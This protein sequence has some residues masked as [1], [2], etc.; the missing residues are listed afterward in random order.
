MTD[1]AFDEAVQRIE[2][3]TKELEQIWNDFVNAVNVV[4]PRLPG[5]LQP[6]AKRSFNKLSAEH[7][8]V[9]E[10]IVKVYAERGSAGAVRQ[11]ASDWNTEVGAKTSELA[12]K[13]NATQMPSHNKWEG[14]AYIAYKEVMA[15][16]STKLGE[17]KTMTDSVHSTLNEI[18]NAPGRR[19]PDQAMPAGH[20]VPMLVR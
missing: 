20:R 2:A 10:K 9:V 11:V 19:H 18:A 8:N 4:L 15:F 6:V 5:Y 3:G 1:S 7:D 14:P 12:Q 13:L 17:V 16:Q